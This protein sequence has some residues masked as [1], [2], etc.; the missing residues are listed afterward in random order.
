[1]LLRQ[2]R[3]LVKGVPIYCAAVHTPWEGSYRV[4]L[5]S[6]SGRLLAQR[7][8]RVNGPRVCY[9]QGFVRR[10]QVRGD[11]RA[12][13]SAEIDTHPEQLFPTYG[14]QDVL[15]IFKKDEKVA[16]AR[17]NVKGRP[18]GIPLPGRLPVEEFYKRQMRPPN[19]DPKTPVELLKVSLGKNGKLEVVIK[20]LLINKRLD[21]VLLARWWVNG[22]PVKPP[23]ADFAL[24][25]DRQD[26]LEAIHEVADPTTSVHVD[27]PS[28][29]Q[30]IKAKAGDLISLQLMYCPG[31]SEELPAG[32]H[33][34]GR[35]QLKMWMEAWDG[36]R[37][38]SV[39]L[40]SN[41]LEFKL[42]NKMVFDM[43]RNRNKRS[44]VK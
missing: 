6:E 5:W 21:E 13:I 40:L 42:T 19:T 4:R 9:W 2:I 20:R 12:D 14:G 17:H 39:P 25:V 3:E 11:G 15:W 29:P 30:H 36:I 37:G 44:Q 31:G 16:L 41:R 26:M 32:R 23:P 38:A 22:Q 1:M 34:G 43:K 33:G 7:I 18:R 10:M 35:E 8:I 27:L 24:E 28:L